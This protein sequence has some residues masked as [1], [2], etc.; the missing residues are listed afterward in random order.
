MIH[1]TDPVEDLK[2]AQREFTLL[3]EIS[4]AM[5]TTLELEHILYIILTGVTAHTGLSFNR[6]ILFLLNTKDKCLEPKMAIGP[7]SGDHAQNI[8]AYIQN[9]NQHLDDLIDK[10]RLLRNS[11]RSALFHSVKSLKIPIEPTSDNLL[12]AA[13]HQ[14]TPFHITKEEIDKYLNDPLLMVFHTTELI[15]MPLKA[16]DKVNGLIIADNFFT[17]KPIEEKDIRIFTM[18]ANQAGLAIE[19]SQ[20]YEKIRLQSHTDTVTSLWNHGFFQSQLSSEIEAAR[21]QNFPTSL[22]IL[23][24]DDF[25]KLNDSHGH[26]I[27][28][29]ILKDIAVILKESSRESDFVCRYGGEEFSLILTKTHT[30]QACTI[31]ER[32]RQKVEQKLF[33]ALQLHVTVSVGLATFPDNASSKEELITLADK[34]MYKAKFGGKNQIS[35]T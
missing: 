13:F 31:A 35:I 10:D 16:K 28:D 29:E 14:G 32:I 25:K 22:I 15:V 1:N 21:K 8:W 19:N 11:G 3:Y 30:E 17:Q 26:Q 33:T 7:E 23:D 24:I 27:G 18:L 6:A 9:S 34:A 4:N 2:R 5:R 12:A 20:L